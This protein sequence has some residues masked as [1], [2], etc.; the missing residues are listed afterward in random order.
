MVLGPLGLKCLSPVLR[1]SDCLRLLSSAFVENALKRRRSVA[2]HLPSLCGVV[3]KWLRDG[4][5]IPSGAL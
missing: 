2:T 1:V 4:K 5:E 3:A